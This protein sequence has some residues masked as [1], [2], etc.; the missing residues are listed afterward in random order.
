LP[1]C[2]RAALA[3]VAFLVAGLPLYAEDSGSLRVPKVI[4]A[5]KPFSISTK[6]SSKAVLYLVGFGQVARRDVQPGEEVAFASDDIHNAGHYVAML[7]AG[8]SVEQAE[9]DVV[10]AP[11][12]ASLSFIAKPSRLPVDTQG[13]ISGVVYVFDSFHNLVLSSLPVSFQLSSG[14]GS[15]TGIAPTRN[16]V[17]WIKM[18]SAATAGN[19][20]FQA[21]AG[22]ITEARVVQ[23]VAGNPCNLK[24]S[25]K[26]SGSKILLETEPVRDCRGNPLPDGTIVTFSE[27]RN[28]IPAAT[29]DVPLKR[30]VARTEI[31][32]Y[33]GAVI[34]V[35]T[36]VV[37]GNEIRLGGGAR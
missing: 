14:T 19:T 10:S 23:Q 26:Q 28:G 24:M 34:S 5:G 13:G 33:V 22:E 25:G 15:Q 30:D 31:P 21:K 3:A 9:F 1:A 37:M 7:V 35:A 11:H 12:P 17:A 16:G 8:S 18:N 36:G 6:I 32:A 4:E 29:V 27:T 20:K 2:V